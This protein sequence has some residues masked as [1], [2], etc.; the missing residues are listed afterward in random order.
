MRKFKKCLSLLL[1]F[2]IVLSAA[3]FIS[4]TKALAVDYNSLKVHNAIQVEMTLKT[5]PGSGAHAKLVIGTET[6][7]VSFGIQYDTACGQAEYRGVP[8]FMFENV[9]SNSQSYSWVSAAARD[10]T[11]VVKL[12]YNKK[13]YVWAYVDG[14]LMG[15]VHNPELKKKAV[16]MRCEGAV[17]VAGDKVNATFAN[18]IPYWFKNPEKSEHGGWAYNTICGGVFGKNKNAPKVKDIGYGVRIKG[19]AHFEGDWDSN[20]TPA[21]SLIQVY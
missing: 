16:T 20:P 18:I 9:T 21:S 19:T 1:A 12:C 13:G 6:A 5:T 10:K 8:A 2:A 17:R 7:A 4:P 15:G 11:F 14:Q 3:V